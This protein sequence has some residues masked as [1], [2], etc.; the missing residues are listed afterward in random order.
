MI[1]TCSFEAA[2]GC[3]HL[4]CDVISPSSARTVLSLCSVPL[5]SSSY[6]CIKSYLCT[7]FMMHVNVFI[8]V[9]CVEEPTY[10]SIQ[11]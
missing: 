9:F 5:H 6:S 11:C 7:C 8:Y 10:F 4:E 2:V 1:F 3:R